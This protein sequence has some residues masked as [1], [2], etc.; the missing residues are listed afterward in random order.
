LDGLII[1]FSFTYSSQVFTLKTFLCKKVNF[2]SLGGGSENPGNPESSKSKKNYKV[3]FSWRN[4]E[5][6]TVRSCRNY[7]KN[8][9]KRTLRV[10]KIFWPPFCSYSIDW[11]SWNMFR[12]I[13]RSIIF[14]KSMTNW[15][16]KMFFPRGT[17]TFIQHLSNNIL[18]HR[19]A[20]HV[21]QTFSWFF[22]TCIKKCN[23]VSATADA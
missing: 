5:Q 9:V 2:S 3:F 6:I 17:K 19:D 11:I 12:S 4:Y 8:T 20:E 15:R 1:L 18:F 16:K 22:T 10:F 7:R 21:S 14:E 13:M 23:L